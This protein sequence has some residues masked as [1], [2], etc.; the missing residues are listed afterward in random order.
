[1]IKKELKLVTKEKVEIINMTQDVKSF[2]FENNI[3]NGIVTVR[4]LH[5]TTAV[6]I[7]EGESGLLKDA[8]IFF[9]QLI[10]ENVYYHHDDFSVRKIDVNDEY[11]DRKNGFAHLQAMLLGS[12]ITIP[13]WDGKLS[14]GKWQS[15]LFIDFDGRRTE[16]KV[17]VLIYNEDK[18]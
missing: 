1:M 12:S 8:V 6:Y 10:P 5:T 9:S 14:L 16:R 2:V 18:I 3:K 11:K 17:E 13:V 7:N 15:I 4:T